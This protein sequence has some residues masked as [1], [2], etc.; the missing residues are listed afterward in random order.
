[1]ITSACACRCNGHHH[2]PDMILRVYGRINVAYRRLL[3]S[4]LPLIFPWC[5]SFAPLVVGIVIG[6]HP[7]EY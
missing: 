2:V 3:T 4:I 1:M 6:S 7:G 5:R